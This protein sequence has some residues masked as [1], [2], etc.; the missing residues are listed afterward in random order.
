MTIN[1]FK[2]IEINLI[3][4]EDD[5]LEPKNPISLFLIDIIR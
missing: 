1:L 2:N 4:T 5:A 3:F